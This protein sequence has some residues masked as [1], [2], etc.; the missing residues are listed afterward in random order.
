MGSESGE[1]GNV[2]WCTLNREWCALN[3]VGGH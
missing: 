1:G 2:S 3:R